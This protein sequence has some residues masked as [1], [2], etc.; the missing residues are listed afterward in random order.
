[1]LTVGILGA[2]TFVAVWASVI[3]VRAHR[4]P[5][6]LTGIIFICGLALTVLWLAMT[7][8][9]FPSMKLA[10]WLA[11]TTFHIAL[12]LLPSRPVG[13]GDAKLIAGL[14]LPMVW[15]GSATTWL[16][17]AYFSGSAVG[18]VRRRTLQSQRIAFGPYLTGGWIVVVVGQLA[19]V[20]MAYSR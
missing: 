4:L 19:R 18:L 11:I 14:S 15:W 12:A 3:D 13:M 17:L 7:D 20:A 8:G 5:N 10:I 6:E 16:L 9:F 1:M 2:M